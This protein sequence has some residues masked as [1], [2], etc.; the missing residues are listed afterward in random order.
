MKRIAIICLLLAGCDRGLM[1][2]DA[3]EPEAGWCCLENDHVVC[4]NG[5]VK[6]AHENPQ[7]T[8]ICETREPGFRPCT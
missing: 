1:V 7:D 4:E 2:G 5:I 3:C 6:L 8:C